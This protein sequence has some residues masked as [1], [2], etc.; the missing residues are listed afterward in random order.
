[1]RVIEG[2]LSA[3]GVETQLIFLR[4]SPGDGC[5][6]PDLKDGRGCQTV[7]QKQTKG[8]KSFNAGS[9]IW[10]ISPLKKSDWNLGEILHSSLRFLRS[11]L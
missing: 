7:L 3:N 9:P 8:T 5:L 4:M 1:M 11:L 10:A 6:F 2:S